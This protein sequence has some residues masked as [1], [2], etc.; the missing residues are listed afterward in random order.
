MQATPG[1][2]SNNICIFMAIGSKSRPKKKPS[3]YSKISLLF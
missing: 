2:G 3:F 1:R